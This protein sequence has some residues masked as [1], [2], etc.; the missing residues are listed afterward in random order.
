[1]QKIGALTCTV[2][3]VST[4]VSYYHT[5]MRATRLSVA[6]NLASKV[7]ERCLVFS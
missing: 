7:T 4:R 1:M 2:I 5:T 6:T 3:E